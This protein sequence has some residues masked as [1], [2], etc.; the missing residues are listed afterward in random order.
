MYNYR[1]PVLNAVY[2][3]RVYRVH[4]HCQAFLVI[5][6]LFQNINCLVDDL[7]TSKESAITDQSA[8]FL[9]NN[10]R[11]IRGSYSVRTSV[12]EYLYTE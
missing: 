12:I 1:V 2:I 4:K 3:A 11:V 8:S 6:I 5:N 9:L 10:Y 7:V